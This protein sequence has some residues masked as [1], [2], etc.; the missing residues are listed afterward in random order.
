MYSYS[1]QHYITNQFVCYNVPQLSCATNV[2]T[3]WSAESIREFHY[4]SFLFSF[5]EPG[6]NEVL[7]ILCVNVDKY[8]WYCLM[9]YWKT[10]RFYRD[11]D[12]PL[13]KREA[14]RSEAKRRKEKRS[15]EKRRKE[16]KRSLK[17]SELWT[18]Q[19]WLISGS[20]LLLSLVTGYACISKQCKA[21]DWVC[22]EAVLVLSSGHSCCSCFKLV[23]LRLDPVWPQ[24]WGW[25]PIRDIDEFMG[26]ISWSCFI[27]EE[28]CSCTPVTFHKVTKTQWKGTIDSGLKSTPDLNWN[29]SANAIASQFCCSWKKVLL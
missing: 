13:Y 12:G 21:L 7:I 3:F 15:E 11:G 22:A 14:K 28:F 1:E 27:Q 2:N 9:H 24:G 19:C 5:G 23:S 25:T 4:Y 26:N 20:T 29:A 16:K 17:V 18:L 6:N 10:L 8:Y